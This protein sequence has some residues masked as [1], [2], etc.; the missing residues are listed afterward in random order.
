MAAGRSY[1]AVILAVALLR[2]GLGWHLGFRPFDD[3]FITFRYALNIASGQ[4]FVYNLNQP[5]LGTTTPLWTLILALLNAVKLPLAGGSLALSLLADAVTAI[6]LG[7][8][9][10]RLGYSHAVAGSA[11]LLFLCF[12]DD[13]SLSR[14]G[15]E[16]AFFVLLVAATLHEIAARR[17]PSAGLFCGLA[18]L[19]RPEGGVL[20]LV[21][22]L[23]LR[24]HRGRLRGRAAFLS[25]ALML[26]SIIGWGLFAE[27]VFGS[28][29]PQSVV[30]KSFAV[31]TDPELARLSGRNLGL[32]FL[33]GQ[34]GSQIFQRTPWQLNS[35]LTFLSLAA[36]WRLSW[37]ASRSASGQN[38][39]RVLVLGL[40]PVCYVGGLALCHAFTWFPWYYGPIYPFYAILAAVGASH[41]LEVLPC[42]SRVKAIFLPGLVATLLLGQFLTALLVKLPRDRSF[43][44]TGYFRAAGPIPRDPQTTVAAFEIG[45]VGWR[46]WPATVIDVT[47]LVT[48]EAVG[49]PSDVLIERLRPDYLVLKTD[50][51]AAFL[52]RVQDEPWFVQ[53]YEPMLVIADPY[54]DRRFCTYRLKPSRS[55]KKRPPASLPV[56]LRSCSKL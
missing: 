10:R 50:N 39:E 34:S 53:E 28:F 36:F 46:A 8:T 35:L 37:D 33:Q 7:R 14:S 49:A 47:G 9:L 56:A 38:R 24:Q 16:T 32:F 23:S 43:W 27:R 22:L 51:A 52:A 31:R 26:V 54:G 4:G 11:S 13:L 48:P 1:D 3:A 30:A 15:M 45:V 41:L 42:P 19:T 20:I 29:V 55:R 21:L 44:V 17:F 12:F 25:I 2:A 6:L 18:C 40:F 5:V